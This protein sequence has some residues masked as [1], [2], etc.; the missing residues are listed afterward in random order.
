MTQ[1]NDKS[2]DDK[3]GYIKLALLDMNVTLLYLHSYQEFR[4]KKY[5]IF[6]HSLIDA[7]NL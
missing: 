2:G 1:L 5:L 7:I 3:R 6:F 4:F